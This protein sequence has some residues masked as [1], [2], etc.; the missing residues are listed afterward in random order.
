MNF[1]RGGCIRL[2][3]YPNGGL[4]RNFARLEKNE[5]LWKNGE[6]TLRNTLQMTVLAFISLLLRRFWTG[7]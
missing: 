4:P 1:I 6:R 2:P 7:S 3:Y 5:R